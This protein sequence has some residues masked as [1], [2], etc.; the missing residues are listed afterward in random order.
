[1]YSMHVYMY[2]IN[3]N[4]KNTIAICRGYKKKRKKNK[5]CEK[6]KYIYKY[7]YQRGNNIYIHK[8]ILIEKLRE[9][10]R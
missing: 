7:I 9:I 3:I 5:M 4:Y 8:Y 2:E 6:K 10:Y 1:M